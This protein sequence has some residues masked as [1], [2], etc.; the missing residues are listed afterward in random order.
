MRYNYWNM[1]VLLAVVG[2]LQP[3]QSAFDV[4]AQFRNLTTTTTILPTQPPVDDGQ[5]L[6]Y[7]C[8]SKNIPIVS[9]DIL[10]KTVNIPEKVQTEACNDPFDK[11]P[12]MVEMCDSA[13]LKVVSENKYL[14]IVLRGCLTSIY[15]QLP[16]QMLHD[17]VANRNSI[18][19]C[20]E[21]RQETDVI[22][23]I[24]TETCLCST[25]YCNSGWTIR[26]ID[27]RLLYG[28]IGLVFC[29]IR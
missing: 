1:V 15:R 27:Y 23:D 24:V 13:C 17:Y 22:G 6:C 7:T 4:F 20:D 5:L 2:V 21:M 9:K 8:M 29:L 11:E 3:V 10:R 12:S 16:T 14:R 18:S 28:L 26:T 25:S 19:S